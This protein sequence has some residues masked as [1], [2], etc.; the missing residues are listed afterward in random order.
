[1]AEWTT[2]NTGI[3]FD[4]SA[5]MHQY[6]NSFSYT[7]MGGMILGI[8]APQTGGTVAVPTNGFDEK[9]PIALVSMTSTYCG[10]FRTP[11]EARKEAENRITADKSQRFVILRAFEIMEPEPVKTRTRSIK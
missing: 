1:M 9:Y 5:Y 10:W 3:S 2:Y 11:E 8:T 7:Q 6:P 4:P